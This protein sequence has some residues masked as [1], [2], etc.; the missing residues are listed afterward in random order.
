MCWC[1]PRKRTNCCGAPRCVPPKAEGLEAARDAEPVLQVRPAAVEV[2]PAVIRPR[3]PQPPRVSTLPDA[4]GSW[5][6]TRVERGE[7]VSTVPPAPPAAPALRIPRLGE[8]VLRTAAATHEPTIR[9]A[10]AMPCLVCASNHYCPDHNPEP[11]AM[12][13]AFTKLSEPVLRE[14]WDEVQ[15]NS[16]RL[17]LCR[18]HSFAAQID[19]PGSRVRRRWRCANCQGTVDETAKLWYERGLAHGQGGLRP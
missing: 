4:P 10:P 13:S 5:P 6:G 18:G 12:L 14:I 1:D 17:A 15:A 7:V 9:P 19:P 2:E 16:A 3:V 11:V 8:P